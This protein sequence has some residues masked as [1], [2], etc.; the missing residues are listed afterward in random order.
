VADTQV[1]A[2]AIAAMGI[3]EPDGILRCMQKS[4]AVDA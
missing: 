3:A 1:C 4:V 2:D